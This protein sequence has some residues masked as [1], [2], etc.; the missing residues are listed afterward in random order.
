VYILLLII[1]T[2]NLQANIIK[3]LKCILSQS[4]V[5]M[6]MVNHKNKLKINEGNKSCACLTDFPDQWKANYSAYTCGRHP[7]TKNM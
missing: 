6:F 1:V 3:P 4:P 7:Y 5:R 2:S